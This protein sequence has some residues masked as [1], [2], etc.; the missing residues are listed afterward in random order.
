MTP[1]EQ[2]H[3]DRIWTAVDALKSTAKSLEALHAMDA[4]RAI[5]YF[6]KAPPLAPTNQLRDKSPGN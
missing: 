4:S 3:L 5:K 6:E 2:H 1:S